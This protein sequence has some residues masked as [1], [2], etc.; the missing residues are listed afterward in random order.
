MMQW[1]THSQSFVSSF[2]VSF[3]LLLQVR[4]PLSIVIS[5]KALTKYQLIF[6]F[7]FHCKH[8]DRQLCGAWQVHQVGSWI[9]CL[10]IAKFCFPL[11][12]Y[13]EGNM[14]LQGVR[15]LKMR[16]TAIPRSSLLCRS[17][18]KF[19]NSLL[20]YLTFE[21]SF[22]LPNVLFF[23]FAVPFLDGHVMAVIIL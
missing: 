19:I 10:F 13:N 9:S 17:M 14:H 15:S 8:V 2:F 5:R 16:G 7:L 6:R 11:P 20:H 12:V 1:W 4:W 21:A 18:L 22:I 3:I 23:L